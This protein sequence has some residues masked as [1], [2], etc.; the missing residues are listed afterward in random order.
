M[1]TAD[2]SGNATLSANGGTVSSAAWGLVPTL[3][4]FGGVDMAFGGGWAYGVGFFSTVNFVY[5]WN[6]VLSPAEIALL[7]AN[8]FAMYGGCAC[9]R[10]I[11]Q[12]P[13]YITQQQC[14]DEAN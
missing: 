9:T 12:T 6:R 3:S 8:P 13:R 11:R 7:N 10:I 1:G 5:V 14:C 2:V 4:Q